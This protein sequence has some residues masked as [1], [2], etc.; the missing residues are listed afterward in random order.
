MAL[1]SP[2]PLLT[3]ADLVVGYA[4]KKT[5][6]PVA[7]PLQLALWP[8]ELVCLLGPNG[9]G[10]STLLRTLAGLQPALGGQLAVGGQSLADLRAPERARQLSIV[11]TDR[12]DAGNL[13][14]RELV[15]LGRHPH[16][17]WL[18]GLSA[19]DEAQ[20][21]AALEATGT[22]AFAP[23]PVGELSDGERQKVLLARALAQ[24]TPVVL[25]DE[26]TAHLDL[27][28]RVALMRLLHRLARQTGKAILLSTHELDLAL[29]AADRVWLL[30]ATGALRTGT[31]EDLVLSGDFAAAFVHEGL[32]F[33]AATGTFALHAPTGP[34]VQLVGDGAA[35][36]WTRRALERE[37]FVPTTG[38]ADLRV[39][40]PPGS[41]ATWLSQAAG[42]PPQTHATVE[43]LLRALR[44]TPSGQLAGPAANNGLR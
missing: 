16:T 20:V 33:D 26:P 1:P 31:P 19:H 41:P 3:A 15:R 43:E 23:R 34:A 30:P 17:G 36:F 5:P 11:L 9:A 28:N 25:L 42:Q 44:Q 2:A 22:E 27:P 13:T 24:D 37:G 8:G 14:V 10:K 35:A 6:H 7:G 39:T 18:G 12:I 4:A 29:Q 38:P 32:A 21:Q 40:V